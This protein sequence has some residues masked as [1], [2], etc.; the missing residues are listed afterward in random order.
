MKSHQPFH[1]F[2]EFYE[3]IGKGGFDVV[4]GNPPYVEYSRKNS[5]YKIKNYQ[6][7][8]CSNLYAFVMERAT[9]LSQKTG[10]LGLIVPMSI[11]S[12]RDYQ[13]LRT[14]LEKYY[15]IQ[16][17]SNHAIR[18]TSLFVGISQRVSIFI[19]KKGQKNNPTIYTT[20]Y[21]RNKTETS[22]L[23]QQMSWQ[24]MSDMR[25][26][27]IIPKTGYSLEISIL[28]K[29]MDIWNELNDFSMVTKYQMFI[30]DYG[31]TYW[32][33]PFSFTPYLHQVKSFK[34]IFC[35]SINNLKILT[36]LYN[37]NLFYWFYTLISDCWHFGKWHMRQFGA[38][39]SQFSKIE[40][41]LIMY[42]DSLMDS[43]KKNRII[44]F[45]SRIN[46]DLYEYKV[47][48]SKPIIDEIDKVLAKYYGFTEEELDYIINYDIKYRMG[49]EFEG[50]E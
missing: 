26:D 41:Q 43:Y 36:T 20:H 27:G 35:I 14:Y 18:P 21:L 30:K 40:S 17:I 9:F 46:G 2:A 25:F 50:E 29:I 37:S 34:E 31:E 16:W 6:T 15:Y 3:I 22:Y 12:I 42:H 10:V 8:N 1:W 4:I 11:T 39:A 23:F 33:F 32:I 19:G 13:D 5:I 38:T 48:K 44:R 24:Y 47:S 7:D 49:A 28:N 45:D